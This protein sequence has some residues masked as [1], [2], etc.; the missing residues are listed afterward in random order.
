MSNYATAEDL[1][2]IENSSI[3]VPVC[4]CIDTSGSMMTKD[5]TGKSRLERVKEGV[6]A[7]YEAIRKDPIAKSSA[8]ICIVGFNN[9]PY[10]VRNFSVLQDD[11][12]GK[13]LPLFS[14]GK[15]DI[16][17]GVSK[18]LE[19]LQNRKQKYKETGTDYYQ[20]WLII[21]SDGHS[22]ADTQAIANQ[23]LAKAQK[24]VLEQEGNK[25]LIVVPVYIGDKLENDPKALKE[26][27]GFSKKNDVQEIN[28][29]RFADFFIWLGKSVSKVANEGDT[30]E[31]DFSDLFDWSLI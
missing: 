5:D 21:M 19:L 29:T 12:K 15:G 13:K 31:V 7:L 9:E 17:F 8:D 28:S 18:G 2:L 14:S 30:D 10:V 16:G 23:N 22:T 1:E 25:K 6:E 11:E 26:L 24:G 3:R 27:G 4:V 20:P